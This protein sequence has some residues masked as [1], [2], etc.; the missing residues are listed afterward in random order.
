VELSVLIK[1]Q[2]PILE[3]DFEEEARRMGCISKTRKTS[4][5]NRLPFIKEQCSIAEKSSQLRCNVCV[6][7]CVRARACV[8]AR[9]ERSETCEV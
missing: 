9:T 3:R 5:Q 7:V 4:N 2:E 6:C 8:R 1:I